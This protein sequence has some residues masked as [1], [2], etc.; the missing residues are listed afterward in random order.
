MAPLAENTSRAPNFL[1]GGIFASR[2]DVARFALRTLGWGI[3]SFALWFAASRWVSL[4]AAWPAAW[5]IGA[6]APVENMGASWDAGHVNVSFEPDASLRYS[7]G[8]PRGTSLELPLDVRKQTASLP[9]FLALVAAGFA[10]RQLPR[11]LAG[12]VL[13]FFLAAGAIACEA[14]VGLALAGP[15]GRPLFIPSIGMGTALAF[16]YQFG[17]LI[18]PSLAPVALW[19]WVRLGSARL[20]G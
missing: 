9:F 16:G 12:F 5:M 11:A 10:R 2:R 6:A 1:A 17:T 13:L 14:G 7:R 3:V 20:E 19:L 18:V 8:L 15:G 4:A